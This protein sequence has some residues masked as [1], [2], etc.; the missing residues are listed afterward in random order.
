M[1]NSAFMSGDL[2]CVLC[3]YEL[4]ISF[5]VDELFV[6]QVNRFL[7]TYSSMARDIPPPS[8]AALRAHFSRLSAAYL[9]SSSA[10]SPASSRELV[11]SMQVGTRQFENA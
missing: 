4:L 5:A 1:G 7:E 9:A 8:L 2:S 10:S 11:E 6:S 3:F